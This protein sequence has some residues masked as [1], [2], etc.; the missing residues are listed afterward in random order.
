MS[1][2]AVQ[3]SGATLWA[4]YQANEVAA[5]DKYKGKRLL[6]SGSVAGI[7]KSGLT[8]ESVILKLA[9]A[10][11]FM[12]ISAEMQDEE[13]SKAAKLSKGDSVKLL[14]SGNGMTLGFLHLGDCTLR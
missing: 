13:K 11:Q 1:E 2:T 9:T 14:C 6:V 3:V 4:D 8:G 7:D 10:N 12:P 5:D